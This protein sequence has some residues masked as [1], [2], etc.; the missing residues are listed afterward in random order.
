MN[1]PIIST[2]VILVSSFRKFF[3]NE[4]RVEENCIEKKRDEMQFAKL[5]SLYLIEREF[6][7]RLNGNV[8]TYKKKWV[9]VYGIHIP[10]IPKINNSNYLNVIPFKTKD[11]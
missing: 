6:E 7:T 10:L 1:Y 3:K 8:V 11:F 2:Y 9:V 4:S 5:P